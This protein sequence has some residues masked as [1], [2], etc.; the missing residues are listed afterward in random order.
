MFTSRA[1]HRLLLRIDNADLRLTPRGRE[2]GLVGTGRWQR[3]AA[4]RLRFERNVERVRTTTVSIASGER[5]PAARALKQPAVRL[6]EWRQRREIDLDIDPRD[7]A[8]DIASV[9][10]EFKYEGYLPA[11]G[12]RGSI[13]NGGRSRG[14][15]L[16]ILCFPGSPGL[17]QGNGRSLDADTPDHTRSRRKN[18]GGHSRRGR[19]SQHTHR[20][21]PHPSFEPNVGCL[22]LALL[23]A[24]L[25]GIADFRT[26]LSKRAK[27]AGVFLPG[28]L[29]CSARVL[30]RAA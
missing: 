3:F 12:G 4:R 18:P 2:I 28:R 9:E 22:V 30:L 1:E 10:T 6:A 16:G 5:L 27:K 7:A 25:G 24:T 11:S 21:P 26:R 20:S 19:T 23:S 8:I 13:G 17:S 29:E 15:S 14:Q